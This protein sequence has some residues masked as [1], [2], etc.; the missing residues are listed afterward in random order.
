MKYFYLTDESDRS[1]A[2]FFSRPMLSATFR[3]VLIVA[4]LVLLF[5]P[6]QELYSFITRGKI[7][8]SFLLVFTTAL[9]VTSYINLSCGRG[10]I[11]KRDYFDR[12]LKEKPTHEREI[13]FL[14][15]GL[16]QFVFHS[17]FLTL[18]I[19]PPLFVSASLCGISQITFAKAVSV[20]FTASLFCRMF[21]FTAYLLWGRWHTA[22]YWFSQCFMIF[23]IFGTF[24]IVPAINPI[25]IIY[26]LHK[27]QNSVAIS[28]A[29]FYYVYILT[30]LSAV[31]VLVVLNQ[32]L[33]ERHRNRE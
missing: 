26:I 20:I 33:V 18:L 13:G 14:Q 32:K 22:G 8:L 9:V 30:I 27:G 31:F 2:P 29:N 11:I 19:L 3:V 28:S 10:S 25:Q 17:V 21:G 12:Y 1:L 24:D 6:H 7:P 16:I 5:W 4:A 23:F 15:Y